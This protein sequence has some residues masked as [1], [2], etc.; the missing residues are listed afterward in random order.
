MMDKIMTLKILVIEDNELAQRIAKLVLEKLGCQ[1]DIVDKGLDG[2]SKAEESDYDLVFMDIGL[3]DIDG[4]ETTRRIRAS[5][6]ITRQPPIVGLTANFDI[7][8]KPRCL[9]AGMN[10]F[11]LK[12]LTLDKA[13]AI[14]AQW[15]RSR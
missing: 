5:E 3:P 9:E 6:K 4:V 15:V 13:E 7:S 1:V 8:H 14:I 10:D 2:L 11:L 12:P